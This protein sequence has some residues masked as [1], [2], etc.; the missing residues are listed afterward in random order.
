VLGYEESEGKEDGIMEQA[1]MTY[2]PPPL[3]GGW[4]GKKD[5]GEGGVIGAATTSRSG[6]LLWLST[7]TAIDDN[8]GR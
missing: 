8:G 4:M 6:G 7:S 3:V 5:E 1:T 2:P